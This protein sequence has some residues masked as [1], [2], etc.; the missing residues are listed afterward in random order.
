M[1][2][3]TIILFI[4]ILR[5]CPDDPLCKSCQI[6]FNSPANNKCLKCQYSI[7]NESSGTCQEPNKILNNCITYQNNSDESCSLCEFGYGA[8]DE[9]ECQKCPDN[10][11]SCKNS[12]CY[13][14]FKGFVPLNYSCVLAKDNCSDSNCEICNYLDVCRQCKDGFSYFPDKGCLKGISN[15]YIMQDNDK[16]KEC[17]NGY[18]LSRSNTCLKLNRN[19]SGGGLIGFVLFVL[20]IGGLGYAGYLVYQKNRYRLRPLPDEYI[21]IAD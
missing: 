21:D 2:V 16:C 8:N 15:C 20:I 1:R 9:G 7:L 13:A 4:Q 5:A 11:A 10:C 12:Y 14:C 19:S 6:D 17:N 3:I 18:Y